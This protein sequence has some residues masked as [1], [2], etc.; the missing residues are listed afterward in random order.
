VFNWQSGGDVRLNVSGETT[1]ALGT[2]QTPAVARRL[3]VRRLTPVECE[4]LQ[5]FPDG[6]TSVIWERA[7]RVDAETLAYLR[8]HYERAYGVQ[9][10]DDQVRRLMSDAARYR[11]LG[12]AVAVPVAAWI[13]RRIVEVEERAA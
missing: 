6:W 9:L 10:S 12:N 5:G 8:A 2:T 3:G 4:R 11:M 1:G 7:L 13:G